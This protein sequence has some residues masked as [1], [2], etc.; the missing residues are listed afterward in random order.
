MYPYAEGVLREMLA[1]V[2]DGSSKKDGGGG[3]SSTVISS[4][5]CCGFFVQESPESPEHDVAALLFPGPDQFSKMREI[6]AMVGD[7]RTLLVFNRQY[8][9]PEDFGFFG[10]DEARGMM[11]RYRWGYAFQEIA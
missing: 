11:E 10:R 1:G 3:C 5:D 8:T 2:V 6:E 7:K 4:P 9:R